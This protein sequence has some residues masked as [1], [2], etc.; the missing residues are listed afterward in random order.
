MAALRLCIVLASCCMALN[1]AAEESTGWRALYREGSRQY[2]LGD[3]RAALDSFKRA[4]L[5]HEEAGILFDIAEC[6]RQLGENAEAVQAYQSYLRRKPDAPNRADVEALIAKLQGASAPSPA[7]PAPKPST[8][9]PVAAAPAATA[10]PPAPVPPVAPSS[11]TPAPAPSAPVAAHGSVYNPWGTTASAAP[12]PPSAGPPAAEPPT[13][14]SA[15]AA[16]SVPAQT[17]APAPA[18]SPVPAAASSPA[19]APTA[20]ET[21]PPRKKS[22][23]WIA[24]IVVPAVAVL[25]VSIGVTAWYFSP[26]PTYTKVG[27]VQ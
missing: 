26:A 21:A 11:S 25:A 8:S 9:L 3:F 5:A 10:P 20:V 12:P 2:D 18:A 7:A 4:Y 24:A 15:P 19:W 17:E 6:H 22:R 23:A 14:A 27:P 13:T 1:V 16:A